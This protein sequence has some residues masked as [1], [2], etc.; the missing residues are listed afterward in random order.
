MRRPAPPPGAA[1]RTPA[2][3]AGFGPC[4]PGKFAADPRRA[5]RPRG[6]PAPVSPLRGPHPAHGAAW[7]ANRGK[8]R[9]VPRIAGSTPP[10]GAGI[11]PVLEAPGDVHRQPGAQGHHAPRPFPAPAR[12]AVATGAPGPAL[13]SLGRPQHGRERSCSA[14]PLLG[15]GGDASGPLPPRRPPRGP[16]GPPMGGGAPVAGCRGPGASGRSY[17]RSG[18]GASGSPCS[19]KTASAAAAARCSASFLLR[20]DPWPNSRSPT[21]TA[22]VKCFWCSGPDSAITV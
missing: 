7:P 18:E 21:R 15:R 10:R 8:A 9:L 22:T 12:R 2:A 19:A 1:H 11:R 13:G 20:P 14:G 5:R 3:P 16:A 17:G 6:R 4:G